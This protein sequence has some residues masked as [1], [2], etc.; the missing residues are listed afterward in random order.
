MKDIKFLGMT[1][2]FLGKLPL[3]VSKPLIKTDNSACADIT[4]GDI[5]TIYNL[6]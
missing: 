1:Q 5:A 2:C 3:P 6:F 4:F